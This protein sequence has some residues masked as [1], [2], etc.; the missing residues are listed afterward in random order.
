VAVADPTPEQLGGLLA[1]SDTDA[2]IR[3][4][5]RRLDDLPEQQQLETTQEERRRLE[6]ARADRTLDQDQAQALATKEDR[7]VEQLRARLEAEQQRMYG[8]EITN[9]KELAS[10]RAEIDSVQRRIGE[11]EDAELEAMQRAEEID[12]EIADLD[13]QV[14]A[15]SDRLDELTVLRDEAARSILAEIAELEVQAEKQ[16]E[17]MPEDLL[18][19]YDE[20]R[21]RFGGHA[22]GTL[23]GDRCTACGI[24]LS[25]ADVNALVEGPPLTTC[26][27]C[28][29]LMVIT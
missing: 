20:A 1:L 28:Q 7:E 3:R 17:P 26:P 12:A 5:Q 19:R 11:H 15:L 24:S 14:A 2:D 29:R 21:E 13:R 8:G 10:M 23:D 9:A 27:S 25:Y 16:R 4:L 22:V 18:Q 6:E